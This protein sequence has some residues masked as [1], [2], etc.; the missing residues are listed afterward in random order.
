MIKYSICS[1]MF[2]HV[3]QNIVLD[4]IWWISI[5][6]NPFHFLFTIYSLW[7][8][9]KGR[10]WFYS[11]RSEWLIDCSDELLTIRAGM[12][13]TEVNSVS[14][15]FMLTLS[16]SCSEILQTHS[17]LS[18]YWLGESY[19]GLFRWFPVQ[20]NLPV[21]LKY[22]TI[23]V[24]FWFPYKPPTH[25]HTPNWQKSCLKFSVKTENL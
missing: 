19:P 24:L 12:F 2:W 17:C 9:M 10:T 14:F 18:A 6:I 16:E 4:I 21:V 15:A 11:S 7:K 22:S 25:T 1:V 3:M 23:F 5:Y 13:I 8:E 20:M